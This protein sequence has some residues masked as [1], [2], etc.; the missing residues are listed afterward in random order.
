MCGNKRTFR[1]L[2][3]EINGVSKRTRQCGVNNNRRFVIFNEQ[4]KC[5]ITNGVAWMV[6]S[7]VTM[8]D[9]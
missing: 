2:K 8:L 1:S 6:G 4:N 7:Y 5:R 9:V 3:K